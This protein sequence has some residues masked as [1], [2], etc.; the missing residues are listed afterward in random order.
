MFTILLPYS[1]V[2][3]MSGKLSFSALIGILLLYAH[4]KFH[5]NSIIRSK[6]T[7]LC[8]KMFDSP[9]DNPIIRSVHCFIY[10]DI[11]PF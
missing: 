3:E 7:D 6:F 10:T 8:P 11:K 5:D 1:C 2:P 9:Q 4:L